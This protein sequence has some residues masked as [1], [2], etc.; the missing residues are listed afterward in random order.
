MKLWE[1]PLA[2]FSLV[3]RFFFSSHV[4][5]S[6]EFYPFG[7]GM[8]ITHIL[9][10]FERRLKTILC[11]NCGDT[12]FLH[13]DYKMFVRTWRMCVCICV[14]IYVRRKC[15]YGQYK[16]AETNEELNGK[17][18]TDKKTRAKN[19]PPMQFKRANDDNCSKNTIKAKRITELRW[20]KKRTHTKITST[21][22]IQQWKY[23]WIEW[24]GMQSGREWGESE[25]QREKPKFSLA[26]R[27][28]IGLVAY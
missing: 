10:I 7:D 18:S 25:R 16:S 28:H 12:C 27:L 6:V 14:W 5:F 3:V 15:L 20:R 11:E 26:D 22:N 13:T 8:P 1:D 2:F 24:I 4:F 21:N 9:C 19:K 23:D 17:A